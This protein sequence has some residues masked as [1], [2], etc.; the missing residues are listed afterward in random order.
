ERNWGR[1]VNISSVHGLVASPYKACYVACKH[2]LLG[3]TKT[4]ATE[5]GNRCPDV[6][7]HAIC[8]SYVRTPLVEAQ[9]AGQA[10]AH[11][12][13]PAQVVSQVMLAANTVKRLIEPEEV[14]QAVVYVCRPEA[15]SMS[16]ATLTLD[17][18]WLTH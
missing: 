11:G 13:S 18:G 12:I 16:G 10:A 4:L 8:P 1:V 7:A 9:I 14:A 15:W 6:T 3:L 2:A 17:A 5:A